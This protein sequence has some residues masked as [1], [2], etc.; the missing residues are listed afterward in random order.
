MLRVF[1]AATVMAAFALTSATAQ[2][3]PKQ[4]GAMVVTCQ[5]ELRSI[6]RADR[7]HDDLCNKWSSLQHDRVCRARR[8][9]RSVASCLRQLGLHLLG[10]QDRLSFTVIN[11]HQA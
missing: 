10:F 7:N 4:G 5:F 1:A 2:D 3:Q 11:T 8:M 6:L 9:I